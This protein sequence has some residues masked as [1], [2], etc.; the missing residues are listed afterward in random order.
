MD[1]R[2]AMQN[3]LC[4]STPVLYIKR[5]QNRDEHRFQ[6]SSGQCL[7]HWAR[8]FVSSRKEGG[9]RGPGEN[10]PLLAKSQ[11]KRAIHEFLLATSP[12]VMELRQMA[13]RMAGAIHKGAPSC[14]HLSV[15]LLFQTLQLSHD[16]ADP[17]QP[18]LY[19][20]SR[21]SLRYAFRL[22]RLFTYT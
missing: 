9:F 7:V 19:R 13:D 1:L 18:R 16:R 3:A 10:A 12:L 8:H 4:R 21:I 20:Q 17:Q 11:I 6:I 14:R 22:S 15:I 5:F 2:Q